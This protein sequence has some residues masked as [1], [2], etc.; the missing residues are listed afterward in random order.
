MRYNRS[1]RSR[2][3]AGRHL[4]DGGWLFRH[5]GRVAVYCHRCGAPG[6]VLADYRAH[7]WNARFR[8]GRC[9]AS[10]DS[11]VDPWQG[12]ERYRGQRPCG[13]C[14]TQWVV[15]HELRRPEQPRV[16]ALEG[17]CGYCGRTS[18]VSVVLEPVRDDE[19]IDPHFGMPL[20][21][22]EKTRAGLLWA[23]N[24]AHLLA[25]RDYAAAPLRETARVA[26]GSMFSRLP[27]WMKLA[28]NRVLLQ[29]ATERLL[30]Q[31]ANEAA[32]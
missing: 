28:R 7:Q 6:W 22:L 14:G 21:L 17:V 32:R 5:A 16:E 8:C 10:L 19:A 24:E 1:L 3:V 4:D 26:N 31:A 25:L 11:G 15:V 20:R 30:S 9:S 23:Y 29:K 13:H 2:P 18:E 12:K 27:R